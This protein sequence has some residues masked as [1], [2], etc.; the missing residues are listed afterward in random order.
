ADSLAGHLYLDQQISLVSDLL[1]RADLISMRHTLEVRVPFLQ[2]ELIEQSQT[3]PTLLKFNLFQDKILFRRIAKKYLP[4]DLAE[5]RKK[6]F[7]IPYSAWLATSQGQ[8]LLREHLTGNNHLQSIMENLIIPAE[9]MRDHQ[10][11]A[12]DYGHPLWTLLILAMWN[13]KE[14]YVV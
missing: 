4:S 14:G 2:K 12:K 11:G 10:R 1:Y 6:G 9:M 5:K 13:K 7:N 8:A 3:I